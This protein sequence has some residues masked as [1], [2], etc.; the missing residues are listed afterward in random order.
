MVISDTVFNGIEPKKHSFG[1]VPVVMVSGDDFQLAGAFGESAIDSL[2]D[3]SKPTSNKTILKGRQL[4]MEL[5]ENVLHLPKVQR[6]QKGRTKDRELLDRIRIGENVTDED[7][8][9]LLNLRL[10]KIREVHGD[11]IAH[12]IWNK[13]IYLCYSN[14][15][16]LEHN[17]ESL[18]KTNSKA[19]PTAILRPI[20]STS[21]RGL[22]VR[23]HFNE[24]SQATTTLLCVNAK[25]CIQGRNFQPL[26]GL[27]NGA[28]GIVNEI[29]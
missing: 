17:L 16:R 20:T 9:R 27:H 28:P 6:I 22:S 8:E 13:S 29:I 25:V 10:D 24:K 18:V 5:A 15:E 23:S 2:P 21:Q 19:Q 11:K 12:D 14:K 7:A 1:G 3:N 4:Y 26:W